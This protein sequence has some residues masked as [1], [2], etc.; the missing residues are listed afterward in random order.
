MTTTMMSG[1]NL[2]EVP[3]AGYTDRLSA[4]PGDTVNF[5]LSTTLGKSAA[6][7]KEV[8]VRAR[9]TS[10]ISA[11]PNPKGPGIIERDAS[12]YFAERT[13]GI[14]HQP[15]PRGSYAECKST[16][17]L[18]GYNGLTKIKVRIWFCPSLIV[19]AGSKNPFQI[20]NVW[21]WGGRSWGGQFR[22]DLKP[23][24]TLRLVYGSSKRLESDD[25]IVCTAQKRLKQNRWYRITSTL[26]LSQADRNSSCHLRIRER[27]EL[28]RDAYRCS[29]TLSRRTLYAEAMKGPFQLASGGTLNGR[30]EDPTIKIETKDKGEVVFAAWDTSR[31]LSTVDDLSSE[32][33][34]YWTI[35]CSDGIL[36]DSGNTE[37]DKTYNVPMAAQSASLV[38][39]H[40]PTRGVKGRRWDASEF[41]WTKSPEHY[42]AIHFH[43]DD[44]YDFKWESSMKWEVP[45]D[46]PSG[47]YIMRFTAELASPKHEEALPIFICAPKIPRSLSTTKRNKLALLIPTFTYVMYGNHARPDFEKDLWLE[48][49]AKCSPSSYPHNPVLYP[50]YGHSSY[51]FHS[52]QT[53]IHFASHLRPLFNLRPGYITF[54]RVGGYNDGDGETQKNA[55]TSFCSGLRHFPADSHIVSW[56]HHHDYEFDIITDHELH[57]EGVEA[58]AGYTTLMTSTHPEY[59]TPQSLD[60]LQKYR[61]VKGGNLIYLGG[62]GFYWKI[63]ASTDEP[64]T[65]DDED[66]PSNC[67]LLEIRR[68]E[69]G[70]RTWAAEAGEY[71]NLLDGMYGG[72]WRNS[73][74][75]PSKLAGIGFAAQGSFVGKPYRRTCW[76]RHDRNDITDWVFQG[77]SYEDM[78]V[79]GDFGFSGDGAAGYELDRIDPSDELYRDGEIVILAQAHT[80]ADVRYALVPEEVLTPWTNLAGTSNEDAKR[81]DMVY[82]KVPKSG[83]QV[84]S[85][86]SITFCGCLPFNNY[87][88]PVSRLIKN[89]VDKF[90]EEAE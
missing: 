48:R 27:D 74:R 46:L 35:P 59:H 14:R 43:D 25:N 85:V 84:F 75:P 47:I 82:F 77:I 56:L 37:I 79:L 33:I 24:G 50:A 86:G 4:R 17:D 63:A 53:G 41:C 51:D 29:S 73:G 90:M 68:C 83:A 2:K 21:C 19:S 78:L 38:L 88:N 67:K 16:L 32:R 60:A 52:D 5:C 26:V 65:S 34:D 70:V 40:H 36:L 1:I 7:N 58:L 8:N 62:N 20:Q 66:T 22:L 45:P 55:D 72:L 3:L 54:S 89:V 39:H 87:E 57:R 80:K 9:L 18:K 76:G 64:M 61:D 12:Q 13:I 44:V 23:M 30:L 15:I 69:G 11:D 42:G 81:A 31:Y 6:E 10:S 28:S 49:T 71:Y